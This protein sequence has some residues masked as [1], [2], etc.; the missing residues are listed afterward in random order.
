M[1][2][3]IAGFTL[4]IMTAAMLVYIF[5]TFLPKTKH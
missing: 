5:W 4:L 2:N 1:F 3:I